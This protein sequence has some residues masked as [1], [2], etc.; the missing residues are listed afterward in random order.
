MRQLAGLRLLPLALPAV[1]LAGDVVLLA[2]E[3][4]E[5]DRVGIDR[6]DL[7]QGVGDALADRP[8]VA[9]LG[10]DLGLGQAAQDRPLDE[11]HHV[12]GGFVD[13]LVLA[14]AGDRGDRDRRRGER[15]DDPVL[16]PHVVGRA[17]PLAERRAAQRPAP[18]G[19][20]GHAVGQVRVAA[21]DALE[22]ERQPG[23]GHVLAEPGF[24]VGA[25]DA[26]GG[27]CSLIA[28]S[29]GASICTRS[30]AAP[31]P[32]AREP[33]DD[34]VRDRIRRP[35]RAGGD[36]GRPLPDTSARTTRT[37]SRAPTRPRSP[38]ATNSP[39]AKTRPRRRARVVAEPSD[40]RF[41]AQ[42]HRWRDARHDPARRRGADRRPDRGRAALQRPDRLD[43]PPP[44]GAGR[45]PPAG[46]PR[47]TSRRG[48]GSAASRRPPPSA[49]PSTRW[50]TSSSASRANATASTG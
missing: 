34:R 4:A 11:L 8:P 33:A 43:A 27:A 14:E 28:H 46:S 23:A 44:R 1:Q 21:G 50:P 18:P 19:G 25:V 13:A 40:A 30:R 22:G 47:A 16:A 37:R 7:D 31:E 10:E 24:D 36:R 35:H 6:V 12:E 45:A 2:A 32:V 17:E 49:P 15:R 39:A 48:S 5:A 20:V 26:V 29:C 9:L 3:L 41:A 42:R 38:P